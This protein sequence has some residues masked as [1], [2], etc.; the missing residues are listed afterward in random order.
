[1]TAPVDLR[2]VRIK[3]LSEMREEGI[4]PY[5]NAF[6]PTA[7]IEELH[8]RFKDW[9]QERLQELREV[10]ALCGR[11]VL[12]RDFGKSCF[13]HIQ[14]ATGRLQVYVRKD[15]LGELAYQRFKKWVDIGDHVGVAGC[16]FRT[17]TGELTLQA[18]RYQILAKALRPLPEKFH[19]LRDIE[20]RYRK[21]Y[22]DLITNPESVAIFRQR[23]A[24]IRAM[25]DF[26]DRRGFLEVE[27]PVMH[28]IAG[29]AAARPFETFHHALDHML[30]LR[31][32][33]ELY[34]KRLLVGGL[35]KVYEIGKNFRN[36]G[37]STMHNPE[38]TMIEFYQA[39][40]TYEDFM[41]LIEELICWI[42][43]S[44]YGSLVRDYQT[45]LIQFQRPWKRL[46]FT[47]ALLDL[48]HCAPEVVRDL[49]S[50]RATAAAHG[51]EVGPNVSHGQL[52]VELFEHIVEPHLVQPTFVIGY[53]IEVSPLARAN[54]A[55]P[56]IVDRF[57]L[58]I[59]G[60]ELANGFSELN[61]PL[62][63]R[64]RFQQQ[65]EQRRHGDDTAH[66]MDEHYLEA[67]EYGMPPA[68]GAGIGIDRLVMLFT[69]SP[70]IR[71]VVLFPQLRPE[72]C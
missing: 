57:E 8:T 34:L 71:D 7:S 35:D 6:R 2:E 37:L 28:P 49:A 19:G 22:L 21:R 44:L 30:Y 65:A 1:M 51:I 39:Y 64:R 25:R 32:A 50:C 24:I 70:A 46:R 59:A 11:I 10:Y 52:L 33:P 16:L 47:D 15:E 31:I 23:A 62:E 63:Q 60:K 5:P 41:N 26:F 56:C 18:V 69:N 38:F 4:D 48:A 68:A 20:K 12:L 40:A 9:T 61:D 29:G 55:N 14:D 27:T 58:Y 72:G 36:E 67:L 3:K 13:F 66:A 43:E 42:A 17:R 54:D 53:P 45:M